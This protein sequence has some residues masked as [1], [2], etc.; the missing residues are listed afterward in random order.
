MA[1]NQTFPATLYYVYVYLLFN[2][3]IIYA[4]YSYILTKKKLV[5]FFIDTYVAT[6][7]GTVANDN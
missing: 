7:V 6:N 5:M 1:N 3:A 4:Q 2:I